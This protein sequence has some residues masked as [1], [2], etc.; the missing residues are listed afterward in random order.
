MNRGIDYVA[1]P[2]ILASEAVVPELRGVLEPGNVASTVVG[3]L[4]DPGRRAA[5]AARL[6]LVAGQPGSADRTAT[7]LLET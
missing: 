1:L 5:M 3:L 2:N 6:R 4:D 7:A